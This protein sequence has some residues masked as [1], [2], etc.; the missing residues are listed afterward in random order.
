MCVVLGSG[1][2]VPTVLVKNILCCVLCMRS[3]DKAMH[4]MGYKIGYAL[5]TRH[6]PNPIDIV[7]VFSQKVTYCLCSVYRYCCCAPS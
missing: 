5:P 4:S 6:L 2:C 3:I 7:L 1:P